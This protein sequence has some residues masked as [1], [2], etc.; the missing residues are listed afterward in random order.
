VQAAAVQPTSAA[1]TLYEGLLSD[2]WER[3]PPAV[4]ALHSA[5]RVDTDGEF[6]I[7]GPRHPFARAARVIARLP[8]TSARTPVR[9]QI[10]CSGGLECW[11][12]TF[13]TRLLITRQRRRGPD[14]VETFGPLELTFA[15][16]CDHQAIAFRQAAAALRL[17]PLRIPLPGWVAPNVAARES[18]LDDGRIAV[19]VRVR[20]PLIGEIIRYEGWIAPPEPSA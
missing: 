12:R 7:T 4:R 14:L 19:S 5:R 15:V 1:P 3:L 2:D 17:G 6:S 13:G 9:L 8:R 11:R 16:T 10:E 18:A 20:I